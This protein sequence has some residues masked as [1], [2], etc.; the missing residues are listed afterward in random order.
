M[1]PRSQRDK[2]PQAVHEIP[3]LEEENTAS[4]T[5]LTRT[6]SRGQCMESWISVLSVICKKNRASLC[7]VLCTRTFCPSLP[8]NNGKQVPS[9][10]PPNPSIVS[11]SE[12]SGCRRCS[13]P[14]HQ[15]G[16]SS[17]K[18]YEI[19]RTQLQRQR[20]LIQILYHLFAQ[21]SKLHLDTTCCFFTTFLHCCHCA[22]SEEAAV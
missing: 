20:F 13:D 19:Q 12:M 1:Y 5:L 2:F 4:V 11:V 22:I 21:D 16:H 17:M 15:E 6:W 7:C 14:F 10:Q 8:R 18:S 3:H 9:L